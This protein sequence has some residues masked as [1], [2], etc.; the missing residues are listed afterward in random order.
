[1]TVFSLLMVWKLGQMTSL[2]STAAPDCRTGQSKDRYRAG[3]QSYS[4]SLPFVVY[5]VNEAPNQLAQIANF[6]LCY[7]PKMNLLITLL[8]QM[9]RLLPLLSK[10]SNFSCSWL[11]R[12]P[13]F[14]SKMRHNIFSSSK[15]RATFRLNTF[16]T[17]NFSSTSRFS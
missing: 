4:F 16:A 10:V 8:R 17:C 9:Y 15:C 13:Y 5:Y 3:V 2:Y 7:W 14:K 1:M 6:W 12:R 11:A